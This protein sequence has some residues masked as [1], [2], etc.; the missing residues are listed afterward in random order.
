MKKKLAIL[1][2]FVFTISLS[3]QLTHITVLMSKDITRSTLNNNFS[4]CNAKLNF[5]V[6]IVLDTR[7]SNFISVMNGNFAALST[8]FGVSC[9]QLNYVMNGELTRLTINDNFDLI[10]TSSLFTPPISFW[11]A[12]RLPSQD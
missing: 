7:L 1:I 6:T 12:L 5:P 11:P 4:I 2:F 3:A 10:A 9:M 8:A